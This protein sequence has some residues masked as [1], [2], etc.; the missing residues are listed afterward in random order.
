M[1]APDATRERLLSSASD[2]VYRQGYE[3][4][5][6]AQ[7]C[8]AAG[9]RKGSF[10]HFFPS[11]SALVEATLERSWTE[12]LERVL[13]PAFAARTLPEQLQSWGDRLADVHRSH[14]QA[15]GGRVHGCRFG[16]LALE[17]STND[18]VLRDAVADRL[19]AMALYVAGHLLRASE[20]GE[21][22]GEQDHVVTEDTAAHAARGLVAHM[23]GLAV[24]AKVT[25]EATPL[26]RLGADAARLLGLASSGS[27]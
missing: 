4:T 12:H 11:K 7:I 2:L 15:P 13:D 21:W 17:V 27:V 23:E 16:N 10:Y 19:E 3:A 6:V 25:D 5:G 14:Q 9:A 1:N 22:H 26:H 8:A 18:P 20:R 24:L